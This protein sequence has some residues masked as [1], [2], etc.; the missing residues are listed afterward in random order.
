MVDALK[1]H[2]LHNTAVENL[3]STLRNSLIR[4][5]GQPGSQSLKEYR[6]FLSHGGVEPSGEA[7]RSSLLLAIES[8]KT[9]IDSFV[10]S[11]S[12]VLIEAGKITFG[13]GTVLYPLIQL[14]NGTVATFQSM[15]KSRLVFHTASGDE[16]RV[17]FLAENNQKL[18]R[19]L[20]P[21]V[22]KPGNPANKDQIDA[23]QV[24]IRRD[25]TSFAET[26]VPVNIA[27]GYSPFWTHWAKRTSEG[28]ILR[29]DQFRIGASNTRQWNNKG[30]WVEYTHFL[31]QMCNWPVIVSRSLQRL[32]RLASFVGLAAEKSQP[33]LALTVPESV[34]ARFAIREAIGGSPMGE[35]LSDTGI[36]SV[37]DM[38]TQT[39][40]GI[41]Q[42]FFVT[43]E[44]GIGKTH[45]LFHSSLSRA[46][47]LSSDPK[48]GPLYLYISCSGSGLKSLHELVNDA[49]VDTQ[50]LNYSSVLTLCRNGLLALVIDG[51]DELVGGGGYRDPFHLLKPLLSEMDTHGTLLLSARS[52]Y[53]SNQYQTSLKATSYADQVP[54]HHL[55]LE[56][57]RWRRHDIE[58]LFIE[59]P[60]W[61]P[62]KSLLGPADYALLGVPF[63][64]H[65][66]NQ[67]VRQNAPSSGFAGLYTVL[68]D[69]YLKREM[70]KL[71]EGTTGAPVSDVQLRHIFEEVAGLIYESGN[72]YIDMDDFRLAAATALDLEGFTGAHR[73]LGDRL[74]VLCGMAAE[75]DANDSPLFSFD[76]ELFFEVLLADHLAGNA[77]NESLHYDR[78]PE[79]LSRAT[80]GDAAVEALTAKYPD[81]VRSL[82]ES[83]SGHSFGSEA[84]G[85]NLTALISRYIAVENRLP[86]G[87]FSRLD[88]STLDLSA[89]T[90]P[91]V[92]FHQCSFDHLKIRNSSQMQI[93]LESCAIAALEVIS[94]DLS[95]DS[96]RFVNPLRVNDLSFLS[97]SGNIIEF[98]SGWSHIAQ[99]LN[100]QGSKGLDKVIAQLES[101]TVS[102]LEKFAD[103]VIEK[104]AAHGDN[105][106]V[107]ETRTLIPGDG[108]NR[109]MRHPNNPLWANMTEVLVSLDLASTKVINA[110]GSSKT[111]V[112]FR[113][114]SSAIADRNTSIEAI[115]V[116]WA[117]LRAS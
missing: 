110:S 64:A 107:V 10:D 100:G 102:Q 91:A 8:N 95:S 114:P 61:E 43:G 27:G 74:T 16:P 20:M 50:N 111:V 65:V 82:V 19:E 60:S 1:I 52:S 75:M 98:V 66:F 7:L 23:F 88:F 116:F 70:N 81:K 47:T 4:P 44:A 104:L 45:N 90:E 77:I 86:T 108:A 94:E 6:D 49:V 58:L 14:V 5:V 85:R 15:S 12:G 79:A 72:Q 62:Y 11:Q 69:A 18:F 13:T 33:A 39:V 76:H 35:A 115:R 93:R 97:K 22:A 36:E 3:F 57:Q 32:E 42:I 78:A 99:R 2:G 101:A 84:F 67:F 96:L 24:A 59:N 28:Y 9:V 113:V 40:N 30:T 38:S 51:F 17:E 87:S 54:A 80:L 56:L 106:Y 117:Q 103:E 73:A 83:V 21:L 25:L 89:I 109:W 68:I 26:T 48:H 92:H 112:T 29:S 71:S 41:P 105:A 46:R 34:S 31:R 63:F 53:F 55:I 37:V